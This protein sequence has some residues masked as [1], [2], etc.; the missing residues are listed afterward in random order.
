[1]KEKDAIANDYGDTLIKKEEELED[2]KSTLDDYKE[3]V[4]NKESQIQELEKGMTQREDQLASSS[5]NMSE[6]VEANDTLMSDKTNL[7][8]KLEKMHEKYDDL[9]AK[10]TESN[11]ESQ[12]QLNE[13]KNLN[14]AMEQEVSNSFR[15]DLQ[16]K[17][18]RINETTKNFS[19]DKAFSKRLPNKEENTPRHVLQCIR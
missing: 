9:Q 12:K 14:K 11:K 2:M 10:T 3:L 17:L 6:L 4:K 1:M 16:S 7:I 8:E 19:F 18:S 15:A 5:Q 13:L